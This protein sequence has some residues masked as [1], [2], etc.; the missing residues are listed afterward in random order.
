[1]TCMGKNSPDKVTTK[2]RVMFFV[3]VRPLIGTEDASLA[4]IVIL[5]TE[6]YEQG[7]DPHLTPTQE[8]FCSL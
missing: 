8:E 4:A 6:T 7:I 1:M 3:S 5:P 2:V